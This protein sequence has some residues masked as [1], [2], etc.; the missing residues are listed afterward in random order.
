MIDDHLK[1][2]QAQEHIDEIVE[3]VS[4]QLLL[5]VPMAPAPDNPNNRQG[6]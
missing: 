6:G 3:R 1:V 4:R 5:D 2:A